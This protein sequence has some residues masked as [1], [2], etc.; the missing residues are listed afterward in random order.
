VSGQLT[1]AL[2]LGVDGEITEVEMPA[3]A[4]SHLATIRGA[5]GCQLV[6]VVAL[7][8]RLD[9]WLDDEGMY[10]QPV[11]PIATA[12]ARRH[13]FTW[14]PYFGAVV[15]CSVTA[16]GDSIALT[17]DQLRAVLTSLLDIAG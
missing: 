8:Q 10:T 17:R 14:Q 12:L 7:T 6:D 15:L 2:R 3:D 13:G 11:N 5:I 1:V 9:M 16:D 4:D